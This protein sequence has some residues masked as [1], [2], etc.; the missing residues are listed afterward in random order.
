MADETLK[1]HIQAM[2][3]HHSWNVHYTFAQGRQRAVMS[4]NAPWITAAIAKV[5]EILTDEMPGEFDIFL[6]ERDEGVL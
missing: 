3:K 5:C 4:I 1:H 6:V 2:M